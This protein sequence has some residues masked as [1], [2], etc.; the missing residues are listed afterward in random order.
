VWRD[1][2]KESDHPRAKDGKFG[3]GGSSPAEKG[4]AA[5][6][7]ESGAQSSNPAKAGIEAAA[8][9]KPK[10]AEPKPGS[11]AA[12]VKAEREA[13]DRQ[14]AEKRQ[15]SNPFEAAKKDP[16]YKPDASGAGSFAAKALFSRK[17]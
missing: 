9:Q 11:Y 1:D 17:K 10:K 4:N 6:R 14:E 3:S 5:A 7:A 15:R 8:K 13:E 2:F 16:N 12:Q